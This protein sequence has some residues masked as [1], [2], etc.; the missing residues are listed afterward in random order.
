MLLPVIGSIRVQY[1][2][3]TLKQIR[4]RDKLKNMTGNRPPAIDILVNGSRRNHYNADINESILFDAS[5]SY[6]IERDAINF[7]WTS[8]GVVIGYDSSVTYSYSEEGTFEIMLKVTDVVDE[9]SDT[10]TIKVKESNG[11]NGQGND[12]SNNGNGQD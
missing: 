8:D 1:T 4:D 11:N 12:N 9:D 5:G 10:V 7:T 3:G 6:D 2:N